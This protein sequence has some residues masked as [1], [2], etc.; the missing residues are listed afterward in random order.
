MR[1]T[2][3]GGKVEV[4]LVNISCEAKVFVGGVGGIHRKQT[5]DNAGGGNTIGRQSRGYGFQ[6]VGG[7][8]KSFQECARIVVINGAQPLVHSGNTVEQIGGIAALGKVGFINT[9]VRSKTAAART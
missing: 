5:A 7:S 4:V 2:P 8:F 6:P 1:A 3:K 9:S